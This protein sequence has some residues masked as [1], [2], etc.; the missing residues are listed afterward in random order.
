MHSI[1][2]SLYARFP[3]QVLRIVSQL[4]RENGPEEIVFQG[5][6]FTNRDMLMSDEEFDRL[7]KETSFE[8]EP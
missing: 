1:I 3:K 6:T 2:M 8:E 7:K 5:H 4:Y